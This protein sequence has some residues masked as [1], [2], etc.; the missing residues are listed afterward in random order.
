MEV[1]VEAPARPVETQHLA[2]PVTAEMDC[3]TAFQG[4]HSIIPVVVGVALAGKED[5]AVVGMGAKV[6]KTEETRRITVA[7][8]VAGLC[9]LE[10]LGLVM[11]IKEL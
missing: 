7:V 2:C 4:P 1:G 5:W 10:Q 3:N 8:A 6:L 11:E 9:Y